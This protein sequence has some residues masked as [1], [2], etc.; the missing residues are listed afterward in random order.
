VTN[1]SISNSLFKR[2]TILL[3]LL[4][5]SLALIFTVSVND[6]S[7]TPIN[8]IYV[9]GS[10]GNNDWN[11]LSS[12]HTSGI[13]G[14]K[15]T[16]NNA[17]GT[18]RSNG[19]VHIASGTYNE[20][21]IQ[22]NT[23]MTIIG[24][25]QKNTIIN[26]QQ[27]GNP[28]FTII[29]GV[30]ITIINLTLTKGTSEQG[31]GINNIGDLTITDTTIKDNTVNSTVDD[32]YGGG[33]YNEG[34]LTIN[35][36]TITGNTATG[37][38]GD[39][40]GG[41][42]YNSG[43]LIINNS[44]I[45]NNTATTTDGYADGGGISN[46]G[47]T[48]T[49]NNS[50]ITNNIA[51]G[52]NNA[53]GGGI[54][55]SFL[56]YLTI[57]NSIITNN[58]ATAMG[59]DVYGGGISNWGAFLTINNSTITRN[60]ATATNGNVYGVGISNNGD[61]TISNTTIKNNISIGTQNVI[62]GGIY[63]EGTLNVVDCSIENNNAGDGGGIFNDLGTLYVS[64]CSI[65]NNKANYGGGIANTGTE[66][67]ID[68][69]FTSNNAT[70]DGGALNNNGE[71]NISNIL[72]VTNCTFTSNTAQH[73]A[74]GIMNWYGNLEVISSTLTNN[75]ASMEGNAIS[76]YGPAENNIPVELHFNRI[77]G[78]GE[79]TL[80]SNS[81]MLNATDNW[82]GSN[83]PNFSTMI[84]GIVTY[85][86]WLYMT[87]TAAPLSIPD[88]ST[89][90]LTASFN[91]DTNGTTITQL[92][93]VLGHIPDGSPVTFT[94]DLGNVGSKSVVKYT[95]NGIA[96]AILRADEIAGIAHVNGIT[97]SQTLNS[98]VN[99]YPKSSL[100]L[101]ITPNK[102]NTITGETVIY[103][104]KVGNKGPNMAKDVVMTYIIPQGLEFAGANM[105]N[106]TYTYNKATRTITWI[107]GDVPVGDPNMWL[108][109]HIIKAGNYLINPKLRTSTYDPTLNQ[110]TQS[111][112]FNA[113]NPV[114]I[115]PVNPI[116]VNTVKA[117]KIIS[118]QDTGVPIVPLAIA[119]FSILGGLAA[120]R[121][122]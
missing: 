57:N 67:V 7:A 64:G 62:G 32:V 100:Y 59:G 88:G 90:T 61:L 96:T 73:V 92:D 117:A 110:N 66:T 85:S 46:E 12:T 65:Q 36:S 91:Q 120:N 17:T 109:L 81:N 26:G 71:N 29:S 68:T 86:P 118:M 77:T 33:I 108:S 99:I 105:D 115:K 79:Y 114:P 112:T 97:D 13:N 37:T 31:G 83:N 5:L 95:L 75:T 35:N 39:V 94:T 52:T 103:T 48:L 10:S 101:T 89:S 119:V 93:L 2:T 9:N 54:S 121:R 24:Q 4:F 72:N 20:S 82:W 58:S 27:S 69:I 106:G 8:T 25:N 102:T 45:T 98:Q 80:F 74:G 1:K 19:T 18:V 84:S 53:F 15:A 49:I 40:Y 116:P 50:T 28:I 122:K 111:I 51:I 22:I 30:N 113:I 60:T 23:N 63:N 41:G 44:I 34:T 55:H 38:N 70:Q 11:G 3:P 43:T 104:L 47:G 76:N 56:G 78:N 21:N 14:P 16:I 42:I 6:V 87:F 107:I